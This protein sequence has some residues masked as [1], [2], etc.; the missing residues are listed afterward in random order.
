MKLIVGLGNPGEKYLKTRHNLGFMVLDDF[1]KKIL[2]PDYEWEAH[3]KSNALILRPN[4]KLLLI[5]PQT[6]MNASGSAVSV[7]ID[8]LKLKPEEI[9]VVHDELDLP[10]GKIKIRKGG[11]AAGHRGVESII[12]SLESDRFVRVRL[13]IGNIR[14]RRGERGLE[15]FGADNFVTEE[16]GAGERSK[17]KHI[18]KQAVEALDGLVKKG[19][20]KAQNQFN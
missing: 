7:I 8:Y 20:D 12:K 13:G 10:L 16:F 18:L 2:G 5:K 17:V 6:F 15:N 1:A 11:S 19:L 3:K 14:S 9:V 4:P